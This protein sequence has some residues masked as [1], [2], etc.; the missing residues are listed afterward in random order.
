M[1][2]MD[3]KLLLPAYYATVT[4]ATIVAWIGMFLIWQAFK[5]NFG[6]LRSVWMHIGGVTLYRSGPR[7]DLL[8]PNLKHRAQ[9]LI[10]VA[11]VI[12]GMLVFAI[13][14]IAA[15]ESGLI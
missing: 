1:A 15:A 13:A 3:E 12:A 2:G 5:R 14:C 10:G 7:A 9:L 11:M 4:C 6:S 8:D